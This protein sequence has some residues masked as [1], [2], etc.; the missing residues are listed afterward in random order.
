VAAGCVAG[1]VEYVRRVKTTLDHLGGALDPH[2]CFLLERGLK[3]LPVRV[4]QQN[5]G[6]RLIAAHL[7]RHP[8]VRRV[9]YPGLP[10]HPQHARASRLLE[11][12]GGVLSFELFGTVE[13]VD[14]FLRRLGIVAVAGSLGGVESLAMRPAAVSHAGLTPEERARMG[15]T[16]SLVRL[17]VG[18]ESPQDLIAD[19]DQALG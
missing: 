2:A 3:T 19:L 14:R 17:S 15:I 9:H 8:R 10:D 1:S 18:L 4:A 16:D 5:E 12:F 13:D 11:G 6:A 7:S